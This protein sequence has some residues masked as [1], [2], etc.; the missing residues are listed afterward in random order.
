M[1]GA[2][3]DCSLPGVGLQLELQLSTDL[4]FDRGTDRAQELIALYTSHDKVW[5]GWCRPSKEASDIITLAT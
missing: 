5:H 3:R 2:Q 1:L 4:S